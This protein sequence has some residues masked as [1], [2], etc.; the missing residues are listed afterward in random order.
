MGKMHLKDLQDLEGRK[1]KHVRKPPLFAI[2]SVDHE[3]RTHVALVG[4]ERGVQDVEV[5]DEEHQATVMSSS[6][7]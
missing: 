1:A 2:R 3:K 4:G 7:T 5:R 6:V